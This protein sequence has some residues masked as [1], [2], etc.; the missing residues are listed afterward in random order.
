MRIIILDE[1][2]LNAFPMRVFTAQFDRTIPEWLREDVYDS[3]NEVK[4]YVKDP[5]I[6]SWLNDFLRMKLETCSE[7][8]S[9][10]R[11]DLIYIVSRNPMG[12]YEVYR[13]IVVE[14]IWL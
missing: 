9:F 6:L 8:Y 2:P 14:G 4:C 7:P 13:V 3:A 10:S 1:F 5:Q 12:G 11:K